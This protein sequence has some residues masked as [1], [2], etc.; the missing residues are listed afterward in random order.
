MENGYQFSKVYSGHV[1]EEGKPTP[2]YFQWARKGWANKRGQRYPMGKGQKPL[3]SWWDGE[4]LGY[5]EARKKIYIPLYAHAV[6]NTEAFARLREEYVKKGSLVLWDFDGYDHRKMKMT[7][8][9]VSNNPHRPMGHAF[10]L[11]HL[12]EKLHPEL[13]KVPKP[14]EPKLTFHELLEIF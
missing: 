10:V 13:V 7:M 4:P 14:E 2:E 9:E 5:I 12:L 11:A 8:K 3:F 6:A 1:D